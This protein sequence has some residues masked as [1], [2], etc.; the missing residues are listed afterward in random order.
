MNAV[1]RVYVW[2]CH[3]PVSYVVVIGLGAYGITLGL[4]LSVFLLW[5]GHAH[6]ITG[7]E[8]SFALSEIAGLV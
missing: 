1:K 6:G 3:S 5:R 8:F 2:A 7:I 4:A